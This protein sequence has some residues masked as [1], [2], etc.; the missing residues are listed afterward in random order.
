MKDM[1][2]TAM[3]NLDRILSGEPLSKVYS[4]ETRSWWDLVDDN[5]VYDTLSNDDFQAYVRLI[6]AIS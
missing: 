6:E 2:T 1:S 5:A 3:H 4:T